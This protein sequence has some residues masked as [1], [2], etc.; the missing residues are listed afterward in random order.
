[1]HR[2]CVFA[3]TNAI[4]EAFRAGCWSAGSTAWSRL[5]ILPGER[6]LAMPAEPALTEPER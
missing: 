3:D 6:E 1:M 5:R 2:I 4:L